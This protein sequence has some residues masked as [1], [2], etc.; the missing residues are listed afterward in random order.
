MIDLDI[1]LRNYFLTCE[2]KLCISLREEFT[3]RSDS[4]FVLLIFSKKFGIFVLNSNTVSK[5]LV[6]PF[7]NPYA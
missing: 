1:Y 3:V 5:G 7:L 2:R 4:V 6:K